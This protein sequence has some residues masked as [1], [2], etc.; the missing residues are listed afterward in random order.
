MAIGERISAIIPSFREGR[1]LLESIRAARTALGPCEVIVVAF[2]ESANIRD[3]ARREG[4][5]WVESTAAN[6]GHQLQLGAEHATGDLFIFV[7]ADSRLP[8]GAAPLVRSAMSVSGVAGG[9]FRLR[10]D[11]GH[12]VLSALSW[13]SRLRLSTSFLGDQ[14]LFCSRRAYLDA[15]G[16]HPEPLFEDVSFARRLS[17]VGA[18]VRLSASVTTSARRFRSH[19]HMRQLVRNALLLAAFHLGASPRRLHDLYEPRRRSGASSRVQHR[20]VA[21][22]RVDRRG[23]R[24]GSRRGASR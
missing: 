24:V 15:G 16:F 18:L 10:F 2:G 21:G 8:V 14:C 13:L 22:R 20:R 9:A 5:L 7:H 17:G 19:G 6:R 1:R 3:A 11:L 12:P 23:A 4:V